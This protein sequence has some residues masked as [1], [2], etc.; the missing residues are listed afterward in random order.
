MSELRIFIDSGWPHDH[1]D[2]VWYLCEEGRVV[3]H[4]HSEPAHWPGVRP[5]VEEAPGQALPAPQAAALI[6]T[7]GQVS[8]QRVRLPRGAAGRRPEVL[9]AALEECLLADPDDC[10]LLPGEPDEEGVAAVAVL[11]RERLRGILALVREMGLA[12]VAVWADAQLLPQRGGRRLARLEGS[13]LTLPLG[14]DAFAMADLLAGSEPLPGAGLEPGLPVVVAAGTDAEAALRLGMLPEL[15]HPGS[16]PLAEPTPGGFL[17]GEFALPVERL[18]RLRPLIPAARL[19]AG[20]A[21]AFMLLLF[22]EWAWLSAQAGR[23]REEAASVFRDAFPQ[24]AVVDPALQMRRQLDERRRR[25][26]RLGEDDFLALLAGIDA[27]EAAWRALDYAGGRLEAELTL[28]TGAVAALES[29][30]RAAGRRFDLRSGDTESGDR[31][32]VR[33]VMEGNGT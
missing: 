10:L 31:V 18:G 33:L 1:A 20:L 13:L 9:V 8:C 17:I 23:M 12:P 16:F 7:G 4:G 22:A 30:L 25:A 14:R 11:S 21:A 5:P 29:Q 27:P 2:A 28:P 6:L 32:R 26:G 15:D 24:A 19:A 3:A